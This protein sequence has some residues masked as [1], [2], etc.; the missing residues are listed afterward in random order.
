[1]SLVVETYTV[2]VGIVVQ[3]MVALELFTRIEVVD[4]QARSWWCEGPRRCAPIHVLVHGMS[5]SG[6]SELARA[7]RAEGLQWKA[8]FDGA[9]RGDLWLD[10]QFRDRQDGRGSITLRS[11]FPSL[12]PAA[13]RG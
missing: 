9:P 5:A 13:L 1:M 2:L 6:S 10:V 12:A 7:D 4:R 3:V 11:E 8:F